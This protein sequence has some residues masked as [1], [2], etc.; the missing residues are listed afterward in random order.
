MSHVAAVAAPFPADGT[1]LAAWE[2]RPLFEW[3]SK[4]NTLPGP[5]SDRRPLAYFHRQRNGPSG[6]L[7]VLVNQTLPYLEYADPGAEWRRIRANEAVALRPQRKLRFGPPGQARD[8]VVEMLS[9][10]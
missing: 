4:P 10:G 1:R 5:T 8:A 3:H 7:W 6:D 2:D 9:L